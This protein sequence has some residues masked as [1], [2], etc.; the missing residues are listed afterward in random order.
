MT[1]D[2]TRKKHMAELLRKYMDDRDGLSIAKMSIA[3][4]VPRTTITDYLRG[5][6]LPTDEN[7]R[8]I[9]E[10]CEW[11]LNDL[12]DYLEYGPDWQKIRQ[13]KAKS[14]M[15]V[16][17]FFEECRRRTDAEQLQAIEILAQ[18]LKEKLDSSK[19]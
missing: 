18:S 1:D 6:S 2:A 10:A 13:G 15:P 7:K 14:S 9:A 11:T 4:D 12:N 19:R 16:E 8:K 5:M 17:L 3:M